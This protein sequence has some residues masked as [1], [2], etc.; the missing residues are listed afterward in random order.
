M[1]QHSQVSVFGKNCIDL[2][3]STSF[4]KRQLRHRTLERATKARQ[5]RERER[6]REREKEREYKRS[7][8]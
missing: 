2:I 8:W 6:E 4:K 7:R 3:I 1:S 5:E